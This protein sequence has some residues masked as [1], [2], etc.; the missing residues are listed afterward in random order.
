M[1]IFNN[2][3]FIFI[4]VKMTPILMTETRDF[5]FSICLTSKQSIFLNRDLC[6]PKFA[7]RN[8]LKTPISLSNL[9]DAGLRELKSKNF[10]I[11]SSQK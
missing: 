3:K 5:S 7:S 1:L 11:L 6:N 4:V 2:V 8:F 9:I 10:F